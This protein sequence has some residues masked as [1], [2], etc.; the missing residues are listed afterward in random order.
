MFLTPLAVTSVAAL[1]MLLALGMKIYV[2]DE[3]K[4]RQQ[5]VQLSAERIN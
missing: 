5:A 3:W 1:I 4:R 2:W